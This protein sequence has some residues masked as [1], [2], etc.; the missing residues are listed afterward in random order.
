MEDL[1]VKVQEWFAL[2]GLK[3]LAAVAIMGIGRY[4]AVGIRSF[5]R[6]TLAR[7]RID[8]TLVSFVSSMAYVAVIV[9]VVVAALGQL[10]VETAS[11]IAVLGAAG[12]AVGLALQ[13]SL[14]NFAA[15]VLILV[16]KP[17]KVGDY[18]EAGGTAGSVEEIGILTVELKSPDNRLVI[19]PNSKVM[20][21]CIVNYTATGTRRLDL[22]V[23][24]GY[25]EDLARVQ[26][27]LRTILDEEPRVLPEPAAKIGVLELADRGVTVAVRPWVKTA[28]YWD[29][30]FD[31]LEKIK[32]RFDAEGIVIPFP[33]MDVHLRRDG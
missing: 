28:D 21:D 29:V 33:Q 32:Q 18:I 3:A 20:G 2:F 14:S 31:M 24:V 19:V 15:G 6:K 1:V 9:F 7:A 5:L 27:V 11:I 13:G 23:S 12:L 22:A 4:A 10:G 26:G 16:F 8:R 25:G 30:R 17:F